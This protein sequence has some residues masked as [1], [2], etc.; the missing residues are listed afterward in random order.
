MKTASV[1]PSPASNA[2]PKWIS[3]YFEG[4]RTPGPRSSVASAPREVRAALLERQFA[5]ADACLRRLVHHAR[6]ADDHQSLSGMR[7]EL[8][9]IRSRALTHLRQA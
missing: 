3:E 7:R 2:P 9:T 1:N 5:S 6:T 4:R 8:Q